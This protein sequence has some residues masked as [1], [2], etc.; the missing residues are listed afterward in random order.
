M[1][2]LRDPQLQEEPGVLLVPN[3]FSPASESTGA[4][5]TL[6]AFSLTC[7]PGVSICES[8]QGP[9]VGSGPVAFGLP[10]RLCFLS[11]LAGGFSPPLLVVSPPGFGAAAWGPLGGWFSFAV[12]GW[13]SG[14]SLGRLRASP[15][16]AGFGLGRSSCLSFLSG[17]LFVVVA[18]G[19]RA[20][21]MTI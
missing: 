16:V 6:A 19:P 4:R 8:G 13:F 14:V 15:L 5:L 20:A 11:L 1:H 9:F 10:C 12:G 3:W 18:G 7:C 17:F 2:Q 21:V